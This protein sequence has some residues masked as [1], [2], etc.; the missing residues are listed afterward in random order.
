MQKE[1]LTFISLLSSHFYHKHEIFCNFCTIKVYHRS[2]SGILSIFIQNLSF[3]NLLDPLSFS[4]R[5]DSARV[6]KY[7]FAKWC[8]IV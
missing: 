6:V 8:A 4:F 3:K 2:A 7:C 1:K 5:L